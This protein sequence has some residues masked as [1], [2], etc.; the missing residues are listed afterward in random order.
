V[1]SCPEAETTGWHRAGRARSTPPPAGSPGGAPIKLLSN[2]RYKEGY[3]K[4]PNLLIN[5]NKAFLTYI[6]LKQ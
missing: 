6:I 5:D 2:S 3:M 1:G 4:A